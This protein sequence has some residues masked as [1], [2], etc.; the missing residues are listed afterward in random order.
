M[1]SQVNQGPPGQM[2]GGQQTQPDA[3][4]P[5]DQGVVPA[6]GGGY[7]AQMAETWTDPGK[8]K[9]TLARVGLFT[10][11]Q[12]LGPLVSPASPSFAFA[13]TPAL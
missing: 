13:F 12:L 1:A 10:S 11:A 8:F 4:L 6:D 5:K 9:R 3:L 7:W 2:N